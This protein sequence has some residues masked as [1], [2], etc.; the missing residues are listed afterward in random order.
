MNQK[1]QKKM[2]FKVFQLNNTVILIFSLFI[3]ECYAE[4]AVDAAINPAINATSGN[5]KVENK[6]LTV[7]NKAAAPAIVGAIVGKNAM[8][9]HAE[10]WEMARSG[11]SLLT[12]PV[13]KNLVAA[14]LNEKQK[15]IEIQYPGGEEGEFWVQELTDWLVSLGIPSKHMITI[16]GS[17]SDDMIRFNLIK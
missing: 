7:Q 14:W 3:T 12:L 1:M 15:M 10:Q 2:S 11:E 17:G 6:A 13:L 8:L 4:A 16:P 5:N 9:L